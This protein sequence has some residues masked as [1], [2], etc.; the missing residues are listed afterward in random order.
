MI[1]FLSLKD[2][3]DLHS[4]EINEAVTRVVN[5]GWYLQGQENERFESN[6]SKFVGTEY[7]IGCA[8]GLDALIWIFR[9]YIEM[10]VMK[11]GD[12]VIV[13]SY[14]FVSTALAFL[15]E[16]A[17]VVFADAAPTMVNVF[18]PLAI[19]NYAHLTDTAYN[20]NGK[21]L[22]EV[23]L[24]NLVA[25]SRGLLLLWSGKSRHHLHWW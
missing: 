3:T 23:V 19:G 2:V 13:P 25:A 5:S 8:N 10:G 14:T 18:F 22:N 1:P 4:V 16:G 9:A 24:G 6:Y 20:A 12:E 15:R 7:T 11:P 21:K 17:T